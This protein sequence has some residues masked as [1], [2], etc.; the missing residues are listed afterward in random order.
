M[1]KITILLT[2]LAL[3]FAAGCRDEASLDGLESQTKEEGGASAGETA[4]SR[5][6]RELLSYESDL[7]FNW[8]CEYAPAEE[9]SYTILFDFLADSSVASDSPVSD[10]EKNLALYSVTAAADGTL[11]LSFD[12]QT[13][14]GDESID[15]AYRERQLVVEEWD[16]TTVRC[17]GAVSGA[18]LVLRKATSADVLKLGEKLVWLALSRQQ[19]LTGILR[20]G[21]N[22]FLCRYAVDKRARTVG[23]TW[24]DAQSRAARHETLAFTL[25]IADS[26]YALEW[27]PVEIN[28]V[29]C[30][31]LTYTLADT[32]VAL[33]LE[34]AR[35]ESPVSAT[36][37][38]VNKASRQWYLGGRM[39]VGSAHPDL[40]DV[41][42]S[43]YFQSIYFYPY[44][45]D[46]PLRVEV[47]MA[48]G[49]TGNYLF[50]NDYTDSPKTARYDS[51]GDW[52]RFYPSTRG[53]YLKIP[54]GSENPDYTLQR[55]ES[56]LKPFTDFYFHADGLYAVRADDT[57]GAA[58]YLIST[59]GDRWVK[60]R[61]SRV[62]EPDGTEEP[63]VGSENRL[64]ELVAAGMKPYGTFF[65]NSA[66]NFR[67]HYTL[68]PEAGTADLIWIEDTEAVYAE[69]DYTAMARNKAQYKTVAVEATA[70]GVITF[71]EPVKVGGA[72]YTGLTWAD[73][74]YTPAVEGES[75]TIRTPLSNASHPLEY[76][77]TYPVNKY[78][79]GTK[80]FIPHSQLCLP[81]AADAIAGLTGTDRYLF[82]P[83][84]QPGSGTPAGPCAVE[85]FAV[86]KGQRIDIKSFVDGFTVH[87]V[88]Y[89]IDDY[90]VE[91]DRMI[92]TRGAVTGNFVDKDG[93][94]LS[95]EESLR[96][97]A[98]LEKLFF[99][100]GGFHVYKAEGVEYDGGKHYFFLVSPDPA[101]PY[102]IK[103]REA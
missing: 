39:Q 92:F 55:M 27:Q 61:G 73:G 20:D 36:P 74:K 101:Y 47:Y 23:F 97:A 95:Q 22:G 70:Q 85:L 83:Y 2:T 68:N 19:A 8:V 91:G 51:E 72:T 6:L 12:G 86:G 11:T 18:S 42:V 82:Y 35:L 78:E 100:P 93:N 90:R 28:G 54:S 99:A 7:E 94:E 41:V 67:L 4:E 71:A 24:I 1:K 52:L 69:G 16:E 17:A 48:D 25:D 3:L 89:A 15:P 102:W 31:R 45:D 57:N 26:Y 96:L 32:R 46:I 49:T 66:K 50:V 87:T 34:G 30:G 14:L 33:D 5:A 29:A 60:V 64:P 81:T 77:F 44:A 43:D 76:F 65:E 79:G 62:T 40:W 21:S 53:D 63:P 37:D 59:T 58:F 13:M 9:K 75:C 84:T 80:V 56:D 88:S 10:N 103:I 38:F 98:P